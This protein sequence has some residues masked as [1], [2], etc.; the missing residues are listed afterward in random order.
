MNTKKDAS[1]EIIQIASDFRDGMLDGKPSM[2]M[3]FAVCYV[4]VGY[5]RFTG[6]ECGLVEGKVGECEHYWIKLGAGNIIDPTADQFNQPNG[7]SM[8]KTYYGK[9][10]NWYIVPPQH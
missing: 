3:C 7:E 8:P 2:S 10:P 9:K 1:A 4:L 5:L 6:Y